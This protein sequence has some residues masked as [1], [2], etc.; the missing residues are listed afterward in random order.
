VVVTAFHRDWGC[1]S[2]VDGRGG[3]NHRMRAKDY[4]IALTNAS[5]A[6]REMEPIGGVAYT[7]CVF[8]IE[9]ARQI[10]FEPREVVLHDEG[11]TVADVLDDT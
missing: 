7:K 6:N 3:G 9:E 11:T 4:L 5:G 10:V 2:E 8:D 1:T